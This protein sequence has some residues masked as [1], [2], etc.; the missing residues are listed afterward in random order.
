MLIHFWRTRVARNK[1][2]LNEKY[3]SDDTVA[4]DSVT[5]VVVVG[6]GG[7]GEVVVV[8]L[9]MLLCFWWDTYNIL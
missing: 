7:G 8:W 4:T 1:S 6:G 3:V 5:V 9:L 2:G